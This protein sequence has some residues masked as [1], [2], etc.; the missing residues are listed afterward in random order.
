[1]IPSYQLIRF[2]R[3]E[4][5]LVLGHTSSCRTLL[6]GVLPCVGA[7]PVVPNASS[8]ARSELECSFSPSAGQ[9]LW[10]ACCSAVA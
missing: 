7:S 4:R 10:L 8:L 3:E 5:H 2:L 6:Q 1:M 9:K